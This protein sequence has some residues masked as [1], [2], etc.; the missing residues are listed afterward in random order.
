MPPWRSTKTPEIT[1]QS[2]VYIP[3][4]PSLPPPGGR[5]LQPAAGLPAAHEM[6]AHSLPDFTGETLTQQPPTPASTIIGELCSLQAWW[7][8]PLRRTPT[9][10]PTDVH[11]A[12][13]PG[14][15]GGC[16]AWAAEELVGSGG[17]T[18]QPP[19]PC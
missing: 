14:T 2:A 8:K 4:P 10:A 5:V 13:V 3:Q 12:T 18:A 9:E 1:L 15:G 11:V 16:F 19:R 17:P 7:P 6:Q